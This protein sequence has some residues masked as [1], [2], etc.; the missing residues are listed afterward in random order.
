MS[1]ET[2]AECHL[3]TNAL[4]AAMDSVGDGLIVL[5][6]SG[7]LQ[8]MSQVVPSP[9]AHGIGASRNAPTVTDTQGKVAGGSVASESTREALLECQEEEQKPIARRPGPPVPCI[10]SVTRQ[11]SG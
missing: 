7:G 2:I 10:A 11:L 3:K 4:H 1:L 6:K 8:L 9:A 5:D